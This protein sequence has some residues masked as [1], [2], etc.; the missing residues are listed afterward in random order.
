MNIIL[1]TE[2]TSEITNLVNRLSA[3]CLHPDLLGHYIPI[4]PD[5]GILIF[6]V[7]HG[8]NTPVSLFT[9]PIPTDIDT[10]QGMLDAWGDRPLSPGWEMTFEFS[11]MTED[12]LQSFDVMCHNLGFWLVAW[13]YRQGISLESQ[14][15]HPSH[16]TYLFTVRGD[17]FN[18][19]R[20]NIGPR[21]P[22]FSS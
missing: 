12:D 6:A 18:F 10:A 1:S 9:I 13:S 14:L 5:Y 3:T 17:R 22:E 15:R 7:D 21:L 4:P 16:Y 19:S 8:A 11:E 20:L 2:C